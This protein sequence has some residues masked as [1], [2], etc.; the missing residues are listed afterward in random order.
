[1]NGALEDSYGLAACGAQDSNATGGWKELYGPLVARRSPAF[2][3]SALDHAIDHL[4]DGRALDAQNV[5]QVRCLN[6]WLLAYYI[7]CPVDTD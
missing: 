4:A 3:R 7:Q 6:A 2:Y 1:M 5:G